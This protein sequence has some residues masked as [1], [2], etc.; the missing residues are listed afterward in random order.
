[1]LVTQTPESTA[2]TIEAPVVE[3]PISNTPVSDMITVS[4]TPVS[5]TPPSSAPV[6]GLVRGTADVADFTLPATDMLLGLEG[7]RLAAAQIQHETPAGGLIDLVPTS[8][9]F[10]ASG[11]PAFAPTPI[12]Q[13]AQSSEAPTEL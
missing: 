7:S 6:E 4:S 2:E 9:D 11:T 1:P 12:D 8:L 5:S 3:T 10:A 13:P